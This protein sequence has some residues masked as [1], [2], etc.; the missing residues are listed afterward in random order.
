MD[1]FYFLPGLKVSYSKSE[2]Y[3]SGVSPSL[4]QQLAELLGLRIGKLHVRYL[5][6]SLITGKLK[7]A[8]CQALIEK[9]TSR[10]SSWTSRFL[11]FVGRLRL[12]KSVLF[13]MSN[14]WCA[15]FILPSKVIKKVEQLCSS[16]FWKGEA[17]NAIWAKVNGKS[18]V[19]LKQRVVYGWKI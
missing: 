3:F 10:I 19:T 12:I 18:C 11:S 17:R 16:F 8:H 7:S 5:G 1:D 6:V 14:F 13:S 4:Q 2:I 9:I 15:M